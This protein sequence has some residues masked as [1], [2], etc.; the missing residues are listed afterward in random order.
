LIRKKLFL[1]YNI[2][3]LKKVLSKISAIF[4][5]FLVLVSSSFVV[6]DEHYCCN[7]LES[8]S[9]FGRADVCDKG[10]PTCEIDYNSNSLSEKSCCSNN[11]KVI[12]GST[13]KINPQIEIDLFQ[14]DFIKPTFNYELKNF[15]NFKEKTH[16][17]NYL[18]PLITRDLL[19]LI[20][21]FLI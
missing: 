8:F 9:I 5:A 16:F 6:I 11:T 21:R 7:N 13:F 14:L 17:K 2:T 20:Q 19:V 1:P 18:P 12:E 10:M 3:S 15:F 4:L